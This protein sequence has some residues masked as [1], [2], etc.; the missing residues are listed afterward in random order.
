MLFAIRR[1]LAFRP[2]FGLSEAAYLGKSLLRRDS[3]LRS[4]KLKYDRECPLLR[5][6]SAFG[7]HQSIRHYATRRTLEL[8]P[9]EEETEIMSEESKSISA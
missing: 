7:N 1:L 6:K 4:L 8:E 3:G 2:K 5:S 9:E